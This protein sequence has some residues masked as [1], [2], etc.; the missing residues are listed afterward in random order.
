[1]T[2]C[3]T[4]IFSIA[5]MPPLSYFA[6]IYRHSGYMIERHEHYNKQSYRN[7]CRIMTANGP[8]DLVIPVRRPGGKVL[9][10][11]VMIDNDYAWQS[12]HWRT[13]GSAYRNSPFFEYYEDDI[14]PF[15]HRSF[16][17]LFDFNLEILRSLLN[18]LEINRSPNLTGE[19]L[20]DYPEK[21]LDL[22][23]SLHP[24]NKSRQQLP[25]GFVCK[26]YHQVFD[27]RYPFEPDLSILDLLFN[28][29]PSARQHL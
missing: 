15:Y 23:Y 4:V 25:P 27:A 5:Y 29:G 17:R 18:L 21:V 8:H 1:M 11:D 13:I 19:F 9:I 6:A 16:T 3:K 2:A 28:T 7:R 20:A 14:A 12:L 22:R 24:K 26:P 10:R